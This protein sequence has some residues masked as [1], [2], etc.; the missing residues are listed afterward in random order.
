MTITSIKIRCLYKFITH[1]LISIHSYPMQ[2]IFNVII[3]FLFKSKTSFVL[4]GHR[5]GHFRILLTLA[6]IAR[7]NHA[8]N[9]REKT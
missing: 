3:H 6:C 2:F 5:T 9:A 7:L 1:L 4:H 8:D